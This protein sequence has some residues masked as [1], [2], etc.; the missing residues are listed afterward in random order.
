MIHDN[1]DLKKLFIRSSWY[2]N[3]RNCFDGAEWW[4]YSW[5]VWYVFPSTR[6][7]KTPHWL[8]LEHPSAHCWHTVAP[9]WFHHGRNSRNLSLTTEF[10]RPWKSPS[11]T[12]GNRQ[13]VQSL[14]GSFLSFCVVCSLLGFH[15]ERRKIWEGILESFQLWPTSTSIKIQG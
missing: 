4:V 9:Q 12:A 2:L 11:W 10:M 8:C 13:T 14:L 15:M 7:H 3:I 5:S 6:T 1:Q